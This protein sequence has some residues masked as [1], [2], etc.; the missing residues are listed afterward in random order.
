MTENGC[1]NV[2]FYR[3][4]SDFGCSGSAHDLRPQLPFGAVT[5]TWTRL[6]TNIRT[7]GQPHAPG[8]AIRNRRMLRFQCDTGD[9][10]LRIAELMVNDTPMTP[11]QAASNV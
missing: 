1:T 11:R 4:N 9:R 2:K 7:F 8:R 6:L 5:Q 3:I 10:D